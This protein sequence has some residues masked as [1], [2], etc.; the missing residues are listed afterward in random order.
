[1]SDTPADPVNIKRHILQW[2]ITHRCNLFC[3][4]CYQTDR[5]SHMPPEML[6]ETLDKYS[7]F[8]EKHGFFGHV[9]LTG[10]EPLTHP[11]FFK[12]VREITDRRMAVSVLT[13]GTLIDSITA[14]RIAL[15]HPAFVQVSL[16]G[17][18]ETHDAIRGEHSF[19]RA[20]K[21]IDRLN[22]EGVPVMV[23]FT[24]QKTNL[25]SFPK[26]ARICSR[27]GVRKLWWDRVVTDTPELAERLA[28]TTEQFRDLVK[29]AE[30]LRKR[31]LRPD[32]SSLI[33]LERSLQC[34]D[35]GRCYTC[36]PGIGMITILADGGVMP[37]RRLPFVIGNIRDGELDDIISRDELTQRFL[38]SP[39][40]EACAGCRYAETCRGGAKCV[41]YGQ[42]GR[43]FEKD[44]NCFYK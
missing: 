22:A 40:P 44:V 26:L 7:R 15:E 29:K 23:S 18:W 19:I 16:D 31:Y 39:I 35:E 20:L 24:A 30:R 34:M 21:G 17:V 27:H 37:C 2:H 3:A 42:T 43:L 5:A 41:T 38:S 10:G 36:H 13:N 8:L 11:Q 6:R 32:G 4:H 33:S 12:L 1:M 28:L 14:N 9:Y 25:K